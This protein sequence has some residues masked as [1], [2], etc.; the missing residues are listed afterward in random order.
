MRRTSLVHTAQSQA[1][2][3]SILLSIGAREQHVPT[4]TAESQAFW[5]PYC[6]QL[7]LANNTSQRTQR[8]GDMV[9]KYLT[10]RLTAVIF[11]LQDKLT[12]LTDLSSCKAFIGR[13]TWDA[14]LSATATGFTSFASTKVRVDVKHSLALSSRPYSKVGFTSPRRCI[15]PSLRHSLVWTLSMTWFRL[16]WPVG[17][18]HVMRWGWT[19]HTLSSHVGV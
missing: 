12:C 3:E 6:C 18:T 4:D 8:N 7:E 5:S 2:L 14:L 17:V 1:F 11:L 13:I 10:L 16:C 9:C 15:F 19:C